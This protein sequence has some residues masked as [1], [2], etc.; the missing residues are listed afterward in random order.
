MS[1]DLHPALQLIWPRSTSAVRGTRGG[2][3]LGDNSGRFGSVRAETK[4]SVIKTLVIEVQ[5]QIRDKIKKQGEQRND[6]LKK[7]S[8]LAGRP[9]KSSAAGRGGPRVETS[10]LVAWWWSAGHAVPASKYIPE[11][12]GGVSTA[13]PRWRRVLNDP[14]APGRKEP[15]GAQFP[16]RRHRRRP[17]RYRLLPRGVDGM[18]CSPPR[19]SG[20]SGGGGPISFITSTTRRPFCT[21]VLT[22]FPRYWLTW[23]AAGCGTASG[24]LPKRNAAT[25]RLQDNLRCGRSLPIYGAGVW[26]KIRQGT[27]LSIGGAGLTSGAGYALDELPG[28]GI[29][30]KTLAACGRASL[31]V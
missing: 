6:G 13:K 7:R 22:I 14:R 2:G 24:R 16:K 30:W 21:A 1:G 9:G 28:D 18:A 5:M 8:S 17:P 23:R 19:P 12:N 26:R 27:H 4:F 10:I 25:L 31:R 15:G 29:L 20:Y 3:F 11:R